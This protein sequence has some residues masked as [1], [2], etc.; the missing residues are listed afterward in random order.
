[1]KYF[2][3]IFLIPQFTTKFWKIFLPLVYAECKKS[4][5]SGK[6]QDLE[7]KKTVPVETIPA[8]KKTSVSPPT[9]NTSSP[10]TSRSPEEGPGTP[11]QEKIDISAQRK[12]E[13]H[14]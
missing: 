5:Q 2:K 1:M 14:S 3:I 10:S 13:D 11:S 6:T 9:G 4:D 7:S 12:P 8:E